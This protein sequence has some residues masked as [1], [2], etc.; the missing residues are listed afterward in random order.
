M[1][2]IRETSDK[3][4]VKKAYLAQLSKHNPEDDPEGFQRVRKAYEQIITLID[5]DNKNDADDTPLGLFLQKLKLL[6]GDFSKRVS[7]NCWKELLQEDICMQLATEDDASKGILTFLMDNWYL[8]GD[9]LKTL[10]D[11]FNWLAGKDE[12]KTSIPIGF[13]NYIENQIRYE[14]PSYAL[15]DKDRNPDRFISLFYEAER[16]INSNELDGVDELIAEM[17]D[18]GVIHPCFMNVKAR[19]ALI[20]GEKEDAMILARAAFSQYPGDFNTRYIYALVLQFNGDVKDA[21]AFFMDLSD[22]QPM[23]FMAERGIIECLVRLEEYEEARKRLLTILEKYPSNAF[24]IGEFQHVSEMLIDKY[25]KLHQEDPDNI[26]ITFML[27]KNYLN[28]LRNDECY[29][30]L[31]KNAKPGCHPRYYEFM[32]ECLLRNGATGKAVEYFFQDISLNKE[33]RNYVYLVTALYEDGRYD[34]ALRY[35]DE[36]LAADDNGDVTSVANIYYLKSLIYREMN[37]HQQALDALDAGLAANEHAQQ[38]YIGKANVYKDMGK[39]AQSIDCCLEAIDILPY[40]PEPYTIEMDI[41]LMT[42]QYQRILDLANFT[43]KYDING[44]PGVKYYIACALSGLSRDKEALDILNELVLN[45]EMEDNVYQPRIYYELSRISDNQSKLKDAVKYMERAIALDKKEKW[46]VWQLN[47]GRLY[48]NS[49]DNG[50]A[51][52]IYNRMIEKKICGTDPYIERGAIFLMM[53]MNIKAHR[54]FEKAVHMDESGE[55]EYNRIINAFSECKMHIDAL[56][57]AERELKLYDSAE[58]RIQKAWVL[59]N[60]ERKEDAI[61]LLE[62]AKKEFPESDK[63]HRRLAHYYTSIRDDHQKALDEFY[64]VLKL[65]PGWPNIY[66]DMGECLSNLNRNDEAIDLLTEAI[67]K[68]PDNASLYARRGWLYM[69]TNNQL[70][71]RSDLLRAVADINTLKTYWYVNYIYYWLGNIY[72]MY[73][74][75]AKSAQKYYEMSLVWNSGFSSALIA[76]GDLNFYLKN[77]A[78]SI[79]FYDKGILNDPGN[80]RYFLKRANAYEMSEQKRYAKDEY[81]AALN[82]Y[83]KKTDDACKHAHFGECYLGLGK[84]EKAMTHFKIAIEKAGCC[85][86]CPPRVCH[87]A[88]F[89]MCKYYAK[90]GQLEKA[91]ECVETAIKSANC[92]HYNLFKKELLK[93]GHRGA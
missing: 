26:E 48:K 84:Y 80:A 46:P 56:K 70:K 89:G 62:K 11:H 13:L 49:G 92:V 1:L 35:A 58:N 5:T 51:I 41:Y 6:Y 30:L 9:V 53:E 23:Y 22:E 73:F 75:D 36:G 67:E 79:E 17:E 85:E 31:R 77:Y 33:Y 78:Q 57:W 86:Q 81:K 15:F 27:A 82:F 54:D 32:G 68:M 72:E 19:L 12:L 55:R 91:L 16:L 4:A 71:A 64:T 59:I 69:D 87:E 65:N 39:Y 14:Y 42:E 44:Y 47:L 83:A 3:N 34:E 90:K 20:R 43:K 8:P 63:L 52:K 61:A 50:S 28:R 74:N 93:A 25:E 7:V 24:A 10:D 37:Q 2:N 66:E 60:L 45:E 18:I 21:L 76:M 40:N 38:L 29:E 88:Y